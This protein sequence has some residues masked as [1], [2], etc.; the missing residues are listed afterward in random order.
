[1]FRFP[2]DLSP[3]DLVPDAIRNVPLDLAEA[4]FGKVDDNRSVK[5][6]VQ[7]EDAVATSGGPPWCEAVLVP[8]ILSAPKP[9]T[10]QHYLTQDGTKGK[11]QLTTY[12][13]GDRTTIR[14]HKLYWH[15]DDGSGAS[16]IKEGAD[17]DRLLQDLRGDSPRDTQHTIIR[18]VRAGVTF[19][20][21]IRFENLTELELGA[22]LH[23]LQLPEDCAHRLGM[24]KPLGLGSIRISASV[25]VIDRVARYRTWQASGLQED[26]DGTRF[27]DAFARA[28][29]DHARKAQEPM[30]DGQGG[31]RQIARLDSMFRLLGWQGRPEPVKTAYMAR[32]QLFRDRPVLPTPHRVMGAG[33]PRS[34]DVPMPASRNGGGRG[35]RGGKPDRTQNRR[36]TP[37]RDAAP[38]PQ[39]A[40]EAAVQ[41]KPI[42]KDQTR[43]G[44]LKRS[45][46]DWVAVFD[47]DS[48][49]ARIINPG[50]I[51]P[52]CAEGTTAEFY[53]TEQSKKAGIKCRLER[54]L[55][56]T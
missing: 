18:P 46:T 32:P 19:A 25:K 23:A 53:I 42:Q 1:M 34:S 33:E 45:G 5:G 8:H 14:G 3:N 11:E 37:P 52:S 38:R 22:L 50:K 21:R 35:P 31:L 51:D 4:M 49:E 12:I 24:G 15:R 30:L 20:G 39:P 48:R 6:R 17:H 47:G 16:Q 29:L 43:R 36:G 13:D 10:F 7:F 27:R 56:A 26:E 41:P 40:V 9:T 28:M 2:Y 55:G 44:T 54:I